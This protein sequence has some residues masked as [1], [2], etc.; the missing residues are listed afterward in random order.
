MPTI[1]PEGACVIIQI[2]ILII[3][4]P[5][6]SRVQLSI[7]PVLVQVI[8]KRNREHHRKRFVDAWNVVGY[9]SDNSRCDWSRIFARS[10]N[11]GIPCGK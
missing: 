7:P 1:C 8:V 2:I 11:Y 3:V 4:G 5:F 10:I 6:V 9:N